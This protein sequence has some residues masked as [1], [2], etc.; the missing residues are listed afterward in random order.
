MCP[1]AGGIIAGKF[2]LSPA[3][4]PLVRAVSQAVRLPVVAVGLIT[5]FDRAEASSGSAGADPIAIVRTIL[6][7]PQWSWLAAAHPRAL[8][9]APHQ[10]PPSQ[11][12]LSRHLSNCRQALKTEAIFSLFL[13]LRPWQREAEDRPGTRFRDVVERTA[14]IGDD[15]P[16]DAQA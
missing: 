5:D 9:H 1:V 11:P 12:L 14:M 10:Y 6:C 7:D 15:R 16:A 2:P 13:R 4:V 8:V 3:H